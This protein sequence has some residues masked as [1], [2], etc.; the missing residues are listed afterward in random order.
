MMVKMMMRKQQRKLEKNV[1]GLE[2]QIDCLQ[3]HYTFII[4]ENNT[5]TSLYIIN[6]KTSLRHCTWVKKKITS[7]IQVSRAG[8]THSRGG[9]H[10]KNPR[11]GSTHSGGW[12]TRNLAYTF[13]AG[14]ARVFDAWI[15]T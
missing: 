6:E 8:S 1:E 2:Q 10:V 13:H 5:L 7:L 4:N 11:A 3:E 9:E 15:F 12:G 14:I